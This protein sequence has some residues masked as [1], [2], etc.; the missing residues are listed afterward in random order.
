MRIGKEEQKARGVP[1][2]GKGD[3][4][5]RRRMFNRKLLRTDQNG[6]IRQS[7]ERLEPIGLAGEYQVI[8][9]SFAH[10]GFV[11]TFIDLTSK[12]ADMDMQL[13]LAAHGLRIDSQRKP[14]ASGS[15]PVSFA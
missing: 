13:I 2:D 1:D 5:K 8:R 11:K 15:M 3:E 6:G 9:Q 10:E 7:V 14:L 4:V 12:A